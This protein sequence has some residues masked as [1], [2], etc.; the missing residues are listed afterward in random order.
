MGRA[1][2]RERL[3]RATGDPTPGALQTGPDAPGP[4]RRAPATTGG[5]A[6]AG[7]ST[8]GPVGRAPFGDG[9]ERRLDDPEW[10]RAERRRIARLNRLPDPL[11]SWAD[12]SRGHAL[13][14]AALQGL[15]AILVTLPVLKAVTG[16]WL[17]PY[18]AVVALGV[19]VA[20]QA[21]CRSVNR[22]AD[23]RAQP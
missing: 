1:R 14:V 4:V 12:R 3:A 6:P 8:P 13:A 21:V 19:A 11:R 9:A 22:R 16:D 10:R 5:G 23:A 20:L 15:L 17:P 18:A 7:T 2:K